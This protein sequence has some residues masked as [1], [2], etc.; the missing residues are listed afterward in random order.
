MSDALRLFGLKAIVTDAASGIGE[1]IVRTFVKHG[2]EVLAVDLANS[3][4]DTHFRKVS[5]VSGL[6]LD[7]RT[8]DAP[9]Q[10][11][12]AAK[13][14]LG[15]LDIVVNNFDWHRE[16]PLSNSDAPEIQSLIDEMHA[17]ISGI[18]DRSVA[19]LKKSPAG[20]IIAMGCLRS[21]FSV[22]GDQA[23][24][25]SERALHTLMSLQASHCGEFGIT[26]NFI[27][28]GAVMTPLARRIF[29]ADKALRDHCIRVSAAK[30]LAEPVDIA[31]VALFLATDDSVFVSGSGIR[32]DG[33]VSSG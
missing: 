20:R 9:K 23:Y 3:G 25:E 6:A 4:I 2:A 11:M 31:K 21:V 10:L 17:L 27:Q 24:R 14:I 22:D 5:G 28:P 26:A 18:C 7:M 16:S 33:G 29:S 12:A 13:T 1:A 15:G 19:L 30:R 32:A 8:N